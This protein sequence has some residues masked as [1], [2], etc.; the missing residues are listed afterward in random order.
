MHIYRGSAP[1]P[2]LLLLV[3]RSNDQKE[4]KLFFTKT[5]HTTR[6]TGTKGEE[7]KHIY[8]PFNF[9][10]TT[11]N[12]ISNRSCSSFRCVPFR[13]VAT[14]ALGLRPAYMTCLRSWCWVWLSKVSMRGWVKDQAPAFRG[15][16]WAQTMV[17]AF[18]YES[19]FSLS[20]AQGKGFSCSIRVIAVFFRLSMFAARCLC[21]AAYTWP[22]HRIT[23]SISSCEAIVLSACAGSG[24]IHWKCDSP[25]KSEIGERAR[26][27][28]SRDLEKKRISAGIVSQYILVWKHFRTGSRCLRFLNCRFI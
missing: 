25:V 2:L 24:M 8:S 21:S 6:L 26:G 22:E 17:L 4:R 11:P 9:S 1:P 10:C 3:F 27:C 23:R 19:R 5:I 7:E 18:G 16:S 28:R 15:S 13:P 20:C 12:A 14:L